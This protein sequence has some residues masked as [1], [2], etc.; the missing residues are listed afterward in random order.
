MGAD[1]VREPDYVETPEYTTMSLGAA[2]ERRAERAT[3]DEFSRRAKILEALE[4]TSQYLAIET[5]VMGMLEHI[6][7][8]VGRAFGAKYVNFWEHTPD[9]KGVSIVAAYGMQKEYVEHSRA[10]PMP[11]GEAW[12]G[13]AMTT[14][15]TWSTT[16]IL[17][18]PYLPASWLRVVRNQQY[19]G[20]MCSPLIRKGEITGG[21][22]VYYGQLH[23]FDYFEMS[24]ATIVANQA[25][26][27]VE[28]ARIFSDLEAERTKTISI[29]YSLTDGLV[30][31]DGE[32]KV[33]FLN[34]R[35]QELLLI[36]LSDVMGKTIDETIAKESVYLQNLYRIV[37]TARTEHETV[38]VITDGPQKLAL[39]VTRIPVRDQ[40]G[41]G[42]GTMFVLHD[43]THE[44]EV[45]KLKVNFVT[46]ASHQLRTPLTGL[47]WSAE[48]LLQGDLG[49]LNQKQHDTLQGLFDTN[50]HL[51]QLV[52]DLLDTSRI[53]EGN[54]DYKFER[55]DL[56][57]LVEK[58]QL[59]LAAK[60]KRMNV[61]LTLEKPAQL[62]PVLFDAVRFELVVQN[63]V[64]NAVKY[65]KPGGYVRVS[66]VPERDAVTLVVADNGIGIPEKDKDFIFN[67]FYRAENAMKYQT[68]GSGLGLFISKSI[69]EK[70]EGAVVFESRE[71]E[72]TTFRVRLPIARESAHP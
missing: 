30:M 71:G 31:H 69:A 42:I 39:Q 14:G 28:N 53:E 13:R 9:K 25:A 33:T 63:L 23:E 20:L 51:I 56:V 48:A 38:E 44:K 22:C 41:Q 47:K 15:T 2:R 64:D 37:Q 35:A 32:G 19:Q 7:E 16:N 34:P 58:V 49:P 3:P 45:E 54:V 68:E 17:K 59:G 57:A 60:A 11:L 72:G 52:N 65:S 36:G 6:A 61:N 40:A 50:E 18:D 8:T 55:G 5:N 29:I 4:K 1:A 67:K 46:T 24:V 27:A 43:V 12:I 10:H 26:T 66:F 62:P 70:H 21:M